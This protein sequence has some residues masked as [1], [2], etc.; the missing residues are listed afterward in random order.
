M[1]LSLRTRTDGNYNFAVDV[2]LTIRALGVAG[3][4]RSGI[5]N[6]RLAEIVGSRVEGGT[7]PNANEPAFRSHGCRFLLPLIPP[8][9][10]LCSLQ[11]FGVV[12][13]VVDATVRRGIGERLGWNVI[14]KA[15][16]VIWDP[17]LMG[18]DIDHPLEKPEMLHAGVS[19]IGA[20]RA[21]VGEN[22]RKLD[23][24]VAESVGAAE[25]LRKDDATERL[26]A[27]IGAAIIDVARGYRGDHAIF[28]ESYF[29]VKES[30]LVAMRARNHMLRTG[31]DPLDRTASGFLG[32]E[33][34]DSHLRISRDLDAKAAADIECL[35]ANLVDVH[36]EMSGEK[37]D[38]KRGERIIAPIIK[39]IVLGI[40][41]TYDHIVF[42][43]GRRETVEVH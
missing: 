38:R 29:G 36:T 12:A 8:E 25:D 26:V 16:N 13:A 11:H 3:E 5:H 34:T 28:V 35:H 27:R 21:L 31:F 6:A 24:G 32:G 17:D 9:T 33:H 43:R 20:N 42:E 41:L 4:R 19:A 15:Y 10:L 18:A 23:A 37:L 40:P 22:L 39:V 14:A 1:S 7:D 30:T 2:E